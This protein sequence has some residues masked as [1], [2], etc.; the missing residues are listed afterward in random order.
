[1]KVTLER[2]TALGLCIACVD[3]VQFLVVA[4]AGV[5]CHLAFYPRA[6][7]H[8]AEFVLTF[9]ARHMTTRT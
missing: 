8:P 7:A 4:I 2:D 5:R 1:M 9:L 3:A 6:H